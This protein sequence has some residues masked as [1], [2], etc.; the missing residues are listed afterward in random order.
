MPFAPSSTHKRPA[1]L[2]ACLTASLLTAC[3]QGGPPAGAPI[4]RLEVD[5]PVNLLTW[6]AQTVQF[7]AS[8][9]DSGGARVSTP[10]TWTSSA[11]DVVSVRA[12]GT[13]VAGAAIGTA[14]ITAEAGGVRSAPVTVTTARLQQG[15]SLVRDEAI[16]AAPARNAEPG[17]GALGVRF[18]VTLRGVTVTPGQVLIATGDLPFAGR[19]VSAEQ[20]AAGTL[21]TLETVAMTDAYRD[22]QVRHQ[23]H[24]DASGLVPLT[25]PGAPVRVQRHPDGR[26]TLT[27]RVAATPSLRAQSTPAPAPADDVLPGPF[28]K[29]DFNVG[30]FACSSTL[31]TL[32]SGELISIKLD[33]KLDVDLVSTIS[34]GHLTAFGAQ[35]GGEIVGT[36]AGGLDVDLGVQGELKCRAT[37]ARLPI[38]VTGPV[39]A[40]FSPTVP[41][42]LG[43][44]LDGKLKLGKVQVGL[45]GK[46]GAK[47]NAGFTLDVPT[48]ELKPTF[49]LE[50]VNTLVPNVKVLG[51]AD[52]ARLEGGL[53]LHATAG[54]DFTTMPWLGAAAPSFGA[55]DLTVGPRLEGSVAPIATQARVSDYSSSFALKLLGTLGPG[56]QLQEL[57]AVAGTRNQV[58]LGNFSGSYDV[59]I[60]RSPNGTLGGDGAVKAGETGAVTVDLNLANLSILPG[61]YNVDEVQLYRER[62]GQ[63]V[64][65]DRRS[66][67]GT[68]AHFD[69]TWTPDAADAGT[70]VV[71]RAFVT[72][73]AGGSIPLEIDDDAKLSVNVTA[74]T[75]P[76]PPVNQTGTW[77]G[78]VTYAWSR[79]KSYTDTYDNR[80]TDL[81][82]QGSLTCTFSDG[83][84]SGSNAYRGKQT[85]T[86][87]S[88]AHAVVQHGWY[89]TVTDSSGSWTATNETLAYGDGLPTV[90]RSG[91][92]TGGV[93]TVT[94]QYE[95]E[96]LVS[97]VASDNSFYLHLRADCGVQAELDTDPDPNRVV[98]SAPIKTWY[99]DEYSDATETVSVNLV[100]R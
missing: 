78:T 27:Y 59:M 35:L 93:N 70:A 31:D 11:P 58:K 63:L 4:T 22:L 39:S 71:L 41:V 10:V 21:V 42:G 73:R 16:V 1:L 84:L 25:G 14:V 82:D 29:K 55:L 32:I 34:D 23:E 77:T 45:E 3:G 75:P 37:L 17:D 33:T 18:H 92:R 94:R 8:A 5:A 96:T 97:E 38:P 74:P 47:I 99:S 26:V 88:S 61:A 80:K 57:L 7:G 89:R 68:Q 49:K 60:G 46:L 51:A 48:G 85:W 40:F 98:Y 81:Q 86:L 90:E 2:L 69:F 83:Q 56:D 72:T 19:V 9:Y 62:D 65:L 12:D 64:L 54:L 43:M 67:Q 50:P 36:L 28:V 20:T 91:E 24:L 15:A 95:G 6:E 76:E 66:A 53:G 13:V 30:P 100:R 79:T 44:Q 87:T 52:A